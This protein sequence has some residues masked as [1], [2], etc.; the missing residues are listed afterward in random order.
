MFMQNLKKLA[1]GGPLVVHAYKVYTLKV[2]ALF[3]ELKEQS[4]FYRAM[5]VV[6][7]LAYVAEHYDLTRV[8]RWSKGRYAVQLLDSGTKFSC[9][10]GLFD[11]FGLPCSHI[12]RVSS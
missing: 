6:P 1:T 9:E 12:L 5:E 10:C 11:N 2:F 7:G 8:Q 4:E 3:F